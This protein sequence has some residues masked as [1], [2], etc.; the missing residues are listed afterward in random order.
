MSVGCLLHRYIYIYV[1]SNFLA[2]YIY[3]HSNVYPY[4]V[5]YCKPLLNVIPSINCLLRTYK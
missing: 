4:V 5:V 1:E 3:V 2:N